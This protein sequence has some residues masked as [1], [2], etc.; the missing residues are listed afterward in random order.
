M[1]EAYQTI[2]SGEYVVQR[3]LILHYVWLVLLVITNATDQ[4]ARQLSIPLVVR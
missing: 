1:L 2:E 4:P 3:C